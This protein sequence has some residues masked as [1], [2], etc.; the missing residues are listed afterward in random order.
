V[1]YS[2]KARIVDSQQPSSTIQQRNCVFCAV[3]ADGCARNNG[4]RDAI[5]SKNCTATEERC[6]LCD[7]C[8]VCIMSEVD[9]GSS[10]FTIALREAMKR[11]PSAW[12]VQLGHP[13]PGGCK[14][15]DLT[16][17]VGRVSNMRQ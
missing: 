16:L 8:R 9:A 11:E 6:F 2:L 12:G 17:E 14:Y 13:V 5:V 3:R 4:I 15:G 7:P 10:T 1:A